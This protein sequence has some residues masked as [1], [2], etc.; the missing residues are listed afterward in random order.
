MSGE[1]GGA[2]AELAKRHAGDRGEGE[3]REE[4]EGAGDEESQ[5]SIV[6]DRHGKQQV[7]EEPEAERRPAER[8]PSAL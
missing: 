3:D 4:R 7:G 6:R 5:A 8:A 2:E 1:F